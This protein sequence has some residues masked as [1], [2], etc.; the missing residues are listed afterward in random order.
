MTGRMSEKASEAP[1]WLPSGAVGEESTGADHGQ[2]LY[3][4]LLAI[5]W[6]TVSV[7]CRIGESGEEMLA[8]C[9][10]AEVLQMG[11]LEGRKGQG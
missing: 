3:P 8:C 11:R 2:S 9:V 10:R 1:T 4:L 5:T 7:T 6:S